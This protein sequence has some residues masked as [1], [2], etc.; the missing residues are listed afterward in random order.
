MSQLK[1]TS[2]LSK[3]VIDFYTTIQ[4]H[5]YN[6]YKHTILF[7]SDRYIAPSWLEPLAVTHFINSL[8]FDPFLSR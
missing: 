8:N 2:P 5:N 1:L 3:L 4:V 7:A 6:A